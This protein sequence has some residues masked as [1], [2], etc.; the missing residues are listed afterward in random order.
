[1]VIKRSDY[2]SHDPFKWDLPGGQIA[3]GENLA[4]ALEREVKE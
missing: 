4:N 3:F 1:M 2:T